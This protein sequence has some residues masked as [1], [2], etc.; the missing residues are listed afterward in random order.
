MTLFFIGQQPLP[1]SSSISHRIN[2]LDQAGADPPPCAEGGPVAVQLRRMT[3]NH[4][5]TSF[6]CDQ[7]ALQHPDFTAEVVKLQMLRLRQTNE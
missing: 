5:R 3:S 7:K 6:L 2:C 4:H 1:C